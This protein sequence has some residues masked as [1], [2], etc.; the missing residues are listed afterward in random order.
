LALSLEN[1]KPK[2]IQLAFRVSAYPATLKSGSEWTKCLPT[3]AMSNHYIARARVA[4]WV[5][6]LD[7][8]TTHASLSPIRRGFAP[9]FVNYK[10]GAL[11]LQSQV[12]KFTS[13]FSMV[14]GSLRVPRLPP[15]LK[16][17]AMI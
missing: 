10:K 2:T 17:V 3:T 8:I 11:D 14:G 7:Y 1:I 13:C 15:S 9:G 16:L 6:L 4:Q 12:I 5:R